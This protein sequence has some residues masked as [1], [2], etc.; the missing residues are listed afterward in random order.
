LRSVPKET[1]NDRRF[2]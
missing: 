1:I 2:T